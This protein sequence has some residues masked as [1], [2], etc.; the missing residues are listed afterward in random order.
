MP[1]VRKVL[2]IGAGLAGTASAI[3][4]AQAGV[5]VDIAEKQADVSALGS[6]ITLQG[7]A[8][9]ALRELGVWEQAEKLGYSYDSLGLR[10]P[11]PNGTLIVELDE[12]RTGGPDLPATAGMYRPD[13]ARMLMERAI[14]VGAKP[15][16]G[17]APVSLA[18]GRD[19]RR[20][21]VRRRHLR[22]LRPGDRRRRGPV[23]DPSG[24]R[25][26][27]ADN[28]DGHGHL[29]SFHRP[30]GERHPHRPVLRRTQLHRRV[31]PDRAGHPVRLRGREG[32]GP[33][34]PHAGR[35]VVHHPRTGRRLPRAVGRD[36]RF[37]H[38][39]RGSE[40]HVVRNPCRTGAV[41]PRPG[42]HH[43]GRRPRLPADRRP[44]RGAGAGRRPGAHRA[45]ARS[46][47]RST[48][49]CGRNS[50]TGGSTAPPRSS[51]HPCNSAGGCRTASA[52]TSPD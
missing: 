13:L 18:P 39:R 17:V 32:S 10:A 36:P 45:A 20:C 29:A 6:G 1:A 2:V 47:R 40:L 22:P 4:L 15:R 11:D 16:L 28:P 24:D 42:R 51:R 49:N 37:D 14:E 41:E 7:N 31:L 46:Q 9:R 23:V 48:T 44:G 52:A 12:M 35:E 8:L 34:L 38:R 3:R 26:R 5:A 25:H 21:G 50:W 30:P 27:R 19:R 43:R 33:F